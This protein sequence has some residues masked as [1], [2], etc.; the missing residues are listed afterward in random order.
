M[1]FNITKTTVITTR[2]FAPAFL[3]CGLIKNLLF[4]SKE[5]RTQSLI[6]K[7]ALAVFL[8]LSAIDQVSAQGSGW[9]TTSIDVTEF[10]FTPS[11]ID[12]TNSSQT[13]TITVRVTDIERDFWNM[14][15][16]FR[17]PRMGRYSYGLG[18]QD[19]IS[20]DGRDGVY[21]KAVTFYQYAEAG[22]W[23]V[24]NIFIYDGAPS[25]YRWRRFYT[26]DLTARG[27]ATQ[28]QVINTNETVS[29]EISDFSFTP[30]AINSSNGPRNI[31]ITLRAR[32]ETSGVSAIYVSFSNPPG[33]PYYADDCTT[34]LSV[35]ITGANRISGDDH[36]GVYRVVVVAAPQDFPTGI[37]SAS[38]TAR[39]VV[40]N[41]RRL[42][43]AQLAALGYP[44]QLRVVR[45]MFD[46][47]GDGKSDISVFRP[48]DQTW[49][50]NR[51]QS[52]F[53]ATQFGLAA[54]KIVSADYD[55]DARTDISV[56]RDGTWWWINSSDGTVGVT[57]FGL[58]SDIPVPA[59]FD[60]D[61]RSEIAVYRG[62]T[63][64][65]LNRVNNQVNVVQ[66]GLATDKLVAGDYD[67]DG[68]ADQAVFRDGI[69]YLLKSTEG[70]SAIRFGSSKTDKPVP[71]DYDGDG[72]TDLAV[73]RPS[74]GNWYVWSSSSNSLQV[75]NWGLAGDALVSADYDGDGKTDA[76]I[77]RNGTWWILQSTSGISVQ[78]FGLANDKPVPS[79]YIP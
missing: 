1:K 46:F 72:K 34:L 40:Q 10:S 18:I 52:G 38:V 32:D 25:Y 42:S 54:D 7:L 3:L 61:G 11:T 20:G 23:D 19:R 62:G 73:F 17:S 33:C 24:D 58:S 75:V 4:V 51:S 37:Y 63:W 41:Y 48:S 9:P 44:S 65:T 60:G 39:D 66:F 74:E 6:G 30:S 27:F 8:V 64:W 68:R 13:V 14:D 70:F 15:V 50:L 12:T 28:L 57:Q 47:D 79:A 26:S 55:G 35:S 31:T 49:Y 16:T 77:Y 71:A 5:I 36:D 2:L 43:S 45:T 76:A 69:W 53:S 29:P 59:D 21:R 78:Q 67:G 56:Y 22:T